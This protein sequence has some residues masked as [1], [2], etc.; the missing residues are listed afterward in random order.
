[1]VSDL[2]IDSGRIESFYTKEELY[3]EKQFWQGFLFLRFFWGN[4][5][6]FGGVY[7]SA[8]YMSDN[9]CSY[10]YWVL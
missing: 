7:E 9:F 3:L 5:L 10:R 6:F 4:L 1:M 8:N 2:Y